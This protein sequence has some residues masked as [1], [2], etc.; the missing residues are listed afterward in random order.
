M[1]ALE[2]LS[3]WTFEKPLLIVIDDSAD[4]EQP[5][6]QFLELVA[7]ER[8]GTCTLSFDPGDRGPDPAGVRTKTAVLYLYTAGLKFTR[9]GDQGVF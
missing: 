1:G 7:K 5:L 3:E 2:L 9:E 8:I 4:G 6:L